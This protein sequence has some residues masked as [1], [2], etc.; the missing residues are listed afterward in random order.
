MRINIECGIYK[1]KAEFFKALNI[2]EYQYKHRREDLMEWLYNFF[3]YELLEDVFPIMIEIKEIFT[4]E[5]EPLPRRL[6]ESTLQ[7][8]EDYGQYV[9]EHLPKDYEPYSKSRM[10]QE[11]IADFGCEKY[12][13]FNDRSVAARYVGPA[14]EEFGDKRG[15]KVWINYHTYE[16]LS[17]EIKQEW[18]KLLKQYKVDEKTIYETFVKTSQKNADASIFKEKSQHYREAMQIF[19]AQHHILPIRVDYWKIK[20]EK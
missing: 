4:D 8:Q 2:T 9:K 11:A 16:I 12:G 15:D 14:M 17:D 19:D 3:D 7:K 18:L 5:Y 20:E 13:H 10:A 6:V 1:M